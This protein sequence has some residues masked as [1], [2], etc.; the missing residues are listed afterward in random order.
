VFGDDPFYGVREGNE[1]VWTSFKDAAKQAKNLAAGLLA[2][3]LV[4][5]FQAENRTWK[6]LGL[7]SKNRPEWAMMHLANMHIR[8]TTV[9]LYDTLGPDATAYIIDLT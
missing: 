2:L 9:A 5:E 4:Q 7:K 6:T 8:S 1:Y 3:D